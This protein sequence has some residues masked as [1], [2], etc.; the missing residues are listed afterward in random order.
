[1]VFLRRAQPSALARSRG[2]APVHGRWRLLAALAV[3]A[4]IRLQLPAA[5]QTPVELAPA[6]AGTGGCQIGFDHFDNLIIAY[7]QDGQL[8]LETRN[9]SLLDQTLVGPGAEPALAFNSLGVFIAYSGPPDGALVERDILVISRVAGQ[10]NPVEDFSSAGE[11]DRFPSIQLVEGRTPIVAWEK[12]GAGA[13]S[14]ICVRRKGKPIDV[15]GPGERP[16]LV[17]DRLGRA[18]IFYLKDG[19]I[20]HTREESAQ[21]PGIY[22]EEVNI[23][24]TPLVEESPPRV[25]ISSDGTLLVCYSRLGEVFLAND[26]SGSFRDPVRVGPAGAEAALMSVSPQGAVGIAF[27]KDGDLYSTLGNTFFIPPA[28]LAVGGPEED[29]LLAVG[30]NSFA[31]V[32][33][34][35]RRGNALFYATDTG[36]PQAKFNAEPTR[37]EAPLA[38]Q[39]SDESTGA[40]KGWFWDFGDGET[41]RQSNPSHTFERSGIYSVSLRVTGPAGESPLAHKL[42][43]VVQDPSNEIRIAGT[44]AFPGQKG[45]YVP[46]LATHSE[47]AQ[48]FTVVAV[49]DPEAI[50]VRSV[51]QDN[52]NISGL[53]PELFAVEISEDP[54]EPYL[55]VGVLF[56]ISV[57]FEGRVMPPGKNQRFANIVVDVKPEPR[58]GS[59]TRIQLK[60]E[61]GH[62]PL[63]NIFTVG[64]RTVVPVLGDG[65]WIAISKL[66]FPP[67]RFFVRG[68]ADG[69][70]M[71]NLSDAVTTLNYLFMGGPV[72]DCHDAADTTDDGKIDI[73]D[74]AFALNYLFLSG[75]LPAP[76]FPFAGLDPTDDA[77][78]PCNLR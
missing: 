9:P 56:D 2:P 48:G 77:L 78:P 73:S 74:A 59:T 11:E 35:F 20:F 61:I 7:E 49:Y 41:A 8:M 68:D 13:S 60:D 37:G 4:A 45:L 40:I 18:H 58:P 69:N 53:S 15:L 26:F 6:G 19:D 22:M 64:G 17:L 27:E 33:L 14:S 66:P 44:K 21:T 3:V 76:P 67:P 32:F 51:I 52:S 75:I 38:V 36:P 65:G 5:F 46:I 39:F 54:D 72:P 71:L 30:V 1:M 23:T 25:G 29:S 24:E 47:P 70:G 63:S 28:F 42:S 55:R 10:W 16:A 34:A 43:I 57:P 12:R 50:E 31:S 62:P